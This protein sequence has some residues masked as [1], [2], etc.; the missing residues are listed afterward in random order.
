MSDEYH[1][2]VLSSSQWGGDASELTLCDAMWCEGGVGCDVWCV[3]LCTP[4]CL[5]GATHRMTKTSF[6]GVLNPCGGAG[7]PCFVHSVLFMCFGTWCLP[8]VY[9]ACMTQNDELTCCATDEGCCNLYCQ[10]LLFGPC[11]SCKFYQKAVNIRET[12]LVYPESAFFAPARAQR[13]QR[14]SKIK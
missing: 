1:D 10:Y 2:E 11:A 5:V 4:C 3:G 14:S 8:A 13:M 12:R 7:L 9:T 6:E